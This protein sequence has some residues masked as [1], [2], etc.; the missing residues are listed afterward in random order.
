MLP[1]GF[2]AVFTIFI[3]YSKSICRKEND[4]YIDLLSNWRYKESSTNYL[5]A[6]NDYYDY[7]QKIYK[8]NKLGVNY[9]SIFLKRKEGDFSQLENLYFL[10]EVSF[11]FKILDN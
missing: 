2:N 1:S 10:D 7:W 3:F 9:N 8:R 11:S 4:Q 5:S 6:M